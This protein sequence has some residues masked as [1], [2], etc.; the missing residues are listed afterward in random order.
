MPEPRRF[1]VLVICRPILGD[2]ILAAPVFRNLR[3]WRPDAWI[4][5]ACYEG[6]RDLVS[7]HAEIDEVVEMPRPG[8]YGALGYAARWLSLVR[9]LRRHRHDLVLDLMQTDRSSLLCAALR[10]E[11]RVGFVKGRPGLRQRVY[12]DS[13]PWA[14]GEDAPHAVDQYFRPLA[15]V[16]VPMRTRAVDLHPGQAARTA[17]RARLAAAGVD[18]ARPLVACHPGASA[19]NKCWPTADLA[20]ACDHVQQRLGA[21]VLL[22]GGPREADALDAIRTAMASQ[23]VV[24]EETLPLGELAAVLGECDLFFGHDS[25]PMHVAAAVG[26]PV[27]ALFGASAPAQW[28]PLGE[29]HLVLRPAMPCTACVEP[30]LCAPPN[31]YRMHCVRRITRGEVLAA[32][33]SKLEQ[34]V[35][36]GAS[37]AAVEPPADA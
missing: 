5:A 26:T 21:R 4:A 34:P 33:A 27:V 11:R 37:R 2:S 29:G 25:G 13:T 1:R 10:S 14:D 22:L 36:R 12:T 18:R 15:V 7:I 19:A 35:A 28:R 9:R 3:A 16:G 31:P 6:T 17:A 24:I 32:L 23:P 20:A 30:T 8:R